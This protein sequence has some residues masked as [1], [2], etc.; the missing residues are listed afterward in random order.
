MI[1]WQYLGDLRAHP[2]HDGDAADTEPEERVVVGLS[3]HWGKWGWCGWV[4][5]GSNFFIQDSR[6]GLVE[7][8]GTQHPTVQG[9]DKNS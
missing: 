6:R 5:G 1:D 9:S 3:I 8:V 4:G 2:E 7:A